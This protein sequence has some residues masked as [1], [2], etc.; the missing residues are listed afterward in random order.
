METNRRTKQELIVEKWNLKHPQGTRVIYWS[1]L[2]EGPGKASITTS[3]A[4]LFMGHTPAVCIQGVGIMALTHVQPEDQE[5][6]A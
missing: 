3:P 1:G 5:S 4:E 2:K 6:V